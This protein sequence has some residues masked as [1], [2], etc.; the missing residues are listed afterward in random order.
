[1]QLKV[2]VSEIVTCFAAGFHLRVGHG[3]RQAVVGA[4]DRGGWRGVVAQGVG[5][6]T[7]GSWG[8][9]IKGEGESVA[10]GF[11]CKYKCSK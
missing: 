5:N 7:C 6:H 4:A 11:W 8:M 2:K 10:G 3:D 9:G 1:M